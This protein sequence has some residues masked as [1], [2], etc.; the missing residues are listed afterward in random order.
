MEHYEEQQRRVEQLHD[1]VLALD[2]G[3]MTEEEARQ[4]GIRFFS[5]YVE[6][7]RSDA[8]ASL[9]CNIIMVIVF[10]LL[11][12]DAAISPDDEY[13]SYRTARKLL[14]K[15]END[16]YRKGYV[17]YLTDF[18]ERIREQRQRRARQEE[19]AEERRRRKEE[20]RAARKDR[21][22]G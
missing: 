20:R 17:R 8:R 2:P 21:Q 4:A 3:S 12:R 13:E 1:E 22:D 16:T 6:I 7:T 5:A 19:W 18:Q 10:T 14:K 9:G 15:F 11:F